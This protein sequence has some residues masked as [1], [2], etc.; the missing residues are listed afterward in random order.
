MSRIVI[1]FIYFFF[2]YR[3]CPVRKAD[4]QPALA[5]ISIFMANFDILHRDK[6][7]NIIKKCKIMIVL[8]LSLKNEKKTTNVLNSEQKCSFVALSTHKKR[9]VCKT[10]KHDSLFFFSIEFSFFSDNNRTR[11]H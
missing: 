6:K 4:N 2:S 8:F 5:I 11:D 10:K 1:I 7:K 9:I 3:D